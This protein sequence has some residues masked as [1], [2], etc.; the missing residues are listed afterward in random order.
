MTYEVFGGL[1]EL[2]VLQAAALFLHFAELLEGF[3]ELAGWQLARRAGWLR[4]PGGR[5]PV[6]GCG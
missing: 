6:A 1:L 5:L 2:A 3:L 4:G